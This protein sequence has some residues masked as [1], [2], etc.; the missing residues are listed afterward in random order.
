MLIHRYRVQRHWIGGY[1]TKKAKTPLVGLFL[2]LVFMAREKERPTL[3]KSWERYPTFS[4]IWSRHQVGQLR[5]NLQNKNCV[6]DVGRSVFPL[7]RSH[8]RIIIVTGRYQ[9]TNKSVLVDRR[10]TGYCW[11]RA[12][13]GSRYT[14]LKTVT[15]VNRTPVAAVTPVSGDEI[16]EAYACVP[17]AAACIARE[18]KRG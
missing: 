7:S 3:K 4:W 10:R 11:R 8:G 18:N 5:D 16:R 12:R 2:I 6:V 9:W 13:H 14:C 1:L 15:A 17:C